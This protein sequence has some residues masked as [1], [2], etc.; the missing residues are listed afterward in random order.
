MSKLLFSMD[1]ISNE[2]QGLTY[3]DLTN[4]L[5]DDQPLVFAFC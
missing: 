2:L 3:A 4:R 1:F 5:V